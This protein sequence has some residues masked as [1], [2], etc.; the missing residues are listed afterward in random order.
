M[1]P[2]IIAIITASLLFTSCKLVNVTDVVPVN[3]LEDAN[4]I[5]SVE[6]AQSALYGAYGI[7][8]GGTLAFNYYMPAAAS[9][10]GLTMDPAQMG[11]GYGENNVPTEDYWLESMYAGGYKLINMSNHIITKTSALSGSDPRKTRIIGE[12][13]YLR[14]MS[15]FY[16][17]RLFGQFYDTTSN[18]GLVLRLDPVKDAEVIPRSGVKAIYDVINKDLDEAIYETGEFASTFYASK[19]AARALKSKVLL[20]EGR[21]AEAA[22]MAKQVTTSRQRSLEDTFKIVFSKKTLNTKEVILQTPYDVGT[23][24]NNKAYAF[25]TWFVPSAYYKAFMKGDARDT[26]AI[27]VTGTRVRNGKFIAG[28]VDGAPANSDTEYFLR[29]AEIYLVQAE[30]IV[31]SG[32][33]LDDAKAALNAIRKRALMPDITLNDRSDLLEAIRKEKVYELGAESGEEWYDLVRFA[34]KGELDI[35]TFKPNFM[36]KDRYILP[37]PIK[38]LQ[39]SDK[40]VVQNPGY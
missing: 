27:R 7:L 28:T 20:Y 2:H 18:Y 32:G 29:L 33:S 4:A 37:I 5:T 39:A 23:N 34:N 8:N 26:M 14:A 40:R 21:Y 22:A 16:L 35:K 9:L 30:A 1:K 38:S 6:K 17:L 36:G 15:Y 19:I 10:M 11:F 24:I 25:N 3:Q 31:R 13:K 12:A